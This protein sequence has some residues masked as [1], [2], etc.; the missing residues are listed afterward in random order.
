MRETRSSGSVRG[1]WSNPY[2]YRDPL[3]QFCVATPAVVFCPNPSLE[4]I[5][6]LLYG[7]A[8][9]V[10]HAI[11]KRLCPLTS[12]NEIPGSFGGTLK[13]FTQLGWVA[14]GHS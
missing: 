10:C 6:P 3:R 11:G 14:G 7:F 13:S 9:V 2:P 5:W 1:V 8:S 4:T 12:Q